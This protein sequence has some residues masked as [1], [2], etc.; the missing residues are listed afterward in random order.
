M[1]RF[2]LILNAFIFS[3]TLLAQKS[4]DSVIVRY[5]RTYILNNDTIQWPCTLYYKNEITRFDVEYSKLKEF[6]KNSSNFVSSE[7]MPDIFMYRKINDFTN[8]FMYIELEGDVVWVSDT[9]KHTWAIHK[10]KKNILGF[11]CQKATT[12]FR[13]RTYE[14]WF[15]KN[16]PISVGPW[17]FYGLPGLILSVKSTDGFYHFDAVE[18]NMKDTL[19]KDFDVRFEKVLK[20]KKQPYHEY[21][22]NI[23]QQLI[24][25][26]RNQLSNSKGGIESVSF[27]GENIENKYFEI[28]KEIEEFKKKFYNQ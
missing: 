17:K 21:V 16:I 3:S 9:V 1:I 7:G 13:H 12:K 18:I 4:V 27:P 26:L 25:R 22:K 11:E 10:D 5:V 28:S 20:V 6:S 15:S 14:A 24:H 2:F 19:I 23:Q 8:G